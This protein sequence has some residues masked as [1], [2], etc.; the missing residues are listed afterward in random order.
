MREHSGDPPTLDVESPTPERAEAISTARDGVGVEL[1]T[2]RR[3]DS[4]EHDAT[5]APGHGP[6]PTG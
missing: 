3:K 2:V 6:T 4:H 1:V 5:E